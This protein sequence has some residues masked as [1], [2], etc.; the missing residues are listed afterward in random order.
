MIKTSDRRGFQIRGRAQHA[1]GCNNGLAE[2]DLATGRH[3]IPCSALCLV[4][5]KLP[6]DYICRDTNDLVFRFYYP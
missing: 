5:V 2:K 4:R 3:S 6:D 1:D